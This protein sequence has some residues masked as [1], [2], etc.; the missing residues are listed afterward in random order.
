M[1]YEYPEYDCFFCMV[2]NSLAKNEAEEEL[3]WSVLDYV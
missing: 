1:D 2:M 3:I